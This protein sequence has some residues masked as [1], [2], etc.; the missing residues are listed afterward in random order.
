MRVNKNKMEGELFQRRARGEQ[1]SNQ[2]Q[3]VF[4]CF[5]LKNLAD[6]D[7]LIND[8]QDM[9]YGTDCVASWLEIPDVNVDEETLREELRKTQVLVL[10]VTVEL[11]QAIS[12]KRLPKALKIARE[13]NRP[14]LPIASDGSLFPYFTKVVDAIHG[15]SMSD[16]EYPDKLKAQLENLLATEELINEV[17][18]KAFTARIFLS[19]RK[20]DI[21]Y[22]HEFMVKFHDLSGFEA[23]S[24]WYDNFLTAGRVF[25]DE[26]KQSILKSN[27]FALLVTKNLLEKNDS[28]KKNYVVSTEYPF[29]RKNKKRIV[30]VEAE[31]PDRRKL[32]KLFRNIDTTVR[33]DAAD[34]LSAAFKRTLDETAFAG[35]TSTERAYLLGVAYL[36]GI[37]VEKD[38]DRALRLLEDASKAH[39]LPAIYACWQLADIYENGMGVPVD[40]TKALALREKYA[41][42]CEEDYRDGKLIADAYCKIAGVYHNLGEYQNSVDW[43][44]RAIDALSKS[45][46]K[47]D[48]DFARLYNNITGYLMRLGKYEEALEYGIKAKELYENEFSADST[49]AA[50]VYSNIGSVYGEM[51]EY[52]K[53]LDYYFKTQALQMKFIGSGHPSTAMT[54]SN[55]AVVY[56]K[57]GKYQKALE[58]HLQAAQIRERVLGKEHPETAATYHEIAFVYDCLGDGM[59]ALKYYDKSLETKEKILGYNHVET[60]MS[61]QGK[62]ST[63][64]YKFRNYDGALENY[65]KALEIREQALDSDH[66]QVATAHNNI[67]GAYHD[68]KEYQKAAEHFDKALSIREKALGGE[69]PDTA[70]TY[71]NIGYLHDECRDF[72]KAIE[73]YEKALNVRIKALGEKHPLTATTYNNIGFVY[74][75]MGNYPKA[76]EWFIKSFSVFHEALGN[77]HPK[78]SRALSN[79]SEAYALLENK[80]PY[81]DWFNELCL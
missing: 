45:E 42:M 7:K 40:Y 81:Q 80:E 63:L 38:T 66:P 1:I 56:S 47:S 54:I 75:H 15:I 39:G 3:M 23:I 33:V 30:P 48:E 59:N 51:G 37:G 72:E 78:T 55:I 58:T 73:W 25:S 12:T 14:V 70:T 68:M 11:L 69:H 32:K 6:K 67:G 71:H 28:G 29:A 31:E 53:A 46:D 26:I 60:A 35:K 65:K 20:V 34:A 17:D 18:Q 52:Q 79:L 16:P 22:A 64:H 77:K 9:K 13:M 57:L 76:V 27:A 62:G 4:L 74:Y 24:I 19:Y 10:W 36:R 44:T 5:D 2:A 50:S 61:Y 41:Q 49:Y 43:Q 21:N 8:L